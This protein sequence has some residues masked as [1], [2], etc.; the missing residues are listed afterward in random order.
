VIVRVAYRL[1]RHVE[2]AKLP[3]EVFVG[4]GTVLGLSRDPERM[5]IPDVM[6]VEKRRLEGHDPERIFRGLPDL[7]IEV[8][9]TSA[10]KPGGQRRILDYLEAG[11]PLV[12][13]IDVYTHT[14]MAYRP[15]G[16]ARLVRAE[17]ALD[18]EDVVPGFRLPL[19]ELFPEG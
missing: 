6:Y 4:G 14:A 8:D 10:K 11:I 15:D 19:A 7:V 12:W 3:G 5:R 16:S 18:G 1:Q 9:L 2:D 13:A 17:E